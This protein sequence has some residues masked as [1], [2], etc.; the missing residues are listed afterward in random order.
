[1]SWLEWPARFGLDGILAS[2]TKRS[3]QNG[4][5]ATHINT[6][7][8]PFPVMR[9]VYPTEW[10]RV[11]DQEIATR[12]GHPAL[13]DRIDMLIARIDRMLER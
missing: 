12:L 7:R 6:P 5:S 1:M 13:E 11:N 2:A 9:N 4:S 10:D 8:K 3:L